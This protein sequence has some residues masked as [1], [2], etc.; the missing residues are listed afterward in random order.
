LDRAKRPVDLGAEL[1]FDP[2]A[3]AQPIAMLAA[4]SAAITSHERGGLLGDGA[5]GAGSA[6]GSVLAHVENRAHVKRSHRGMRVPCAVRSVLR[7][8]FRESIRIVGE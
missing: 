4:V 1:P 7:E 6:R 8:Y 3:A 2:F 5:H